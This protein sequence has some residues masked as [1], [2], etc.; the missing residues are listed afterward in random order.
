MLI[1]RLLLCLG[2]AAPVVA[3]ETFSWKGQKVVAKYDYPLKVGDRVVP[4]HGFQ[5]YTV[6]RT[7]GDRLWVVAGSV[8]GWI[9]VKQVV[10][11][12]D[13]IKFYTNEL[14]ANAGNFR[15]W[16]YRG[17]IWYEKK[18][19]DRAIADYNEAIKLDPQYA[20]AFNSRG[21]AW[22]AKKDFDKAIA[23]YNEAIRLDPRYVLAY[24]NRG[25]AWKDKKEYDKAIADFTEAIRLDPKYAAAFT[26]RASAW[27]YKN[28]YDKAIADYTEAIR[29]DPKYAAAFT[30]R[31]FAWD[32]KKEYDKAIADYNEVIRLDP[33]NAA[34]YDSLASIWVFCPEKMFRNGNKAVEFATSACKLSDW[35]EPNYLF[36][37]AAAYAEAGEF[38]KAADCQS[39]ANRL[40]TND[41][42]RKRGEVLLRH[43]K[44]MAF[45]LRNRLSQRSARSL[46]AA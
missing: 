29:L 23:D 11:F 22:E 33:K 38:E 19:Y 16:R 39:K 46:M 4:T 37:L 20:N 35:K 8:E 15:A 31:A 6:Q 5:V 36:T 26:F 14:A 10:L 41:D 25:N 3:P 9:P 1:G 18:E 40:Y 27:G 17:I 32:Q 28:E 13:A 42:D 34:A 7:D 43:Y 44:Q 12:D 45:G 24:T 30:F 21:V 2:L